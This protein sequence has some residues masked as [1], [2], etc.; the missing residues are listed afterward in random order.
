M[1]SP[2]IAR[3]IVW[4]AVSPS[5]VAPSP[6]AALTDDVESSVD[7]YSAKS[8]IVLRA[9][10][11]KLMAGKQYAE[12]VQSIQ[13][14]QAAIHR[15]YGVDSIQQ[16]DC[17]VW[18]IEAYSE[19]NQLD[20]ADQQQK[21]LFDLAV[22]TFDAQDPRLQVARLRLADWHQ[23]SLRYQNAL[24]LY[25]K[26]NVWAEQTPPLHAD[27]QRELLLR[28]LQGEALTRYTAG[29]CCASNLLQRAHEIVS[30]SDQYVLEEKEMALRNYTHLL[31]LERQQDKAISLLA[32]RL[33]GRSAIAP[34]LLGVSRPQDV[35]KAIQR[36][37][38]QS[39]D[40]RKTYYIPKDHT[41]IQNEPALAV[42]ILLGYPMPLCGRHLLKMLKPSDRRRLADLYIDVTLHIN[43]EGYADDI[44]M[45]GNVSVKAR[46][47]L[48]YSLKNSQF[49]PQISATGE[50]DSAQF[51]FRQRFT[52][53]EPSRARDVASWN[54]QLTSH[55]CQTSPF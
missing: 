4:F 2:L 53:P 43:N 33:N 45:K 8:L 47:Y 30:T 20:S 1:I 35:L 14:L 13:Q 32:S 15:V 21:F 19:L 12:A 6:V 9:N 39:A 49:R 29:F 48:K 3:I 34:V 55:A 22:R 36:V 54:R 38:Y 24:A 37:T 28:S 10:V 26:I 46:R 18:L 23:R 52:A 16:A 7:Y 25:E 11:F 51:E 50:I 5:L 17:L 40:P 41:V 44:Q 42:P 27:Q 31:I